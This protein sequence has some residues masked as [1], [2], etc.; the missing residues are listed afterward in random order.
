MIRV[1]NRLPYKERLRRL[2]VF[3][4]AETNKRRRDR[5]VKIMNRIVKVNQ[6]LLFTFRAEDKRGT[7][8][9]FK[10]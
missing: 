1:F 8:I 3:T 6:Q 10:Y 7:S 9:K 4:S 5:G 2:V